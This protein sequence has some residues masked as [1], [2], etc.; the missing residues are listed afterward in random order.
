M[1][2]DFFG[3][4]TP[5]VLSGGIAGFV[6]LVKRWQPNLQ[7]RWA[8]LLVIALHLV[9]GVPFHLEQVGISVWSVFEAVFYSGLLAV[10]SMGF[11][12][13][14]IRRREGDDSN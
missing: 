5:I 3:T 4:I 14:A 13:F 9:F 7:D 2:Q 8:E 12:N 1:F 10:W 6:Q 11:Y